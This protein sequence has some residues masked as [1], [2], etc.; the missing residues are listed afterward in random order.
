MRTALN[1]IHDYTHTPL[2]LMKGSYLKVFLNAKNHVN[3]CC[4]LKP[5]V[6]KT[7]A[8]SRRTFYE[9]FLKFRVHF[10]REDG[11]WNCVKVFL[12]CVSLIYPN[13]L[14]YRGALSLGVKQQFSS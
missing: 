10:T 4:A 11:S 14:T 1:V 12:L 9:R 13:T 6:I 7:V 5:K 8:Q 2:T 3:N